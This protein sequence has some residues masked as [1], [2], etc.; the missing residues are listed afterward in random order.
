MDYQGDQSIYYIAHPT[1]I[2]L[3]LYFLTQ[4]LA[5]VYYIPNYVRNPYMST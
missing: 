3:N 4:Y 5:T 2:Y 1:N